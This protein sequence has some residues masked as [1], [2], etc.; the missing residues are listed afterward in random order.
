VPCLSLF[1]PAD[2][3]IFGASQRRFMPYLRLIR[4]FSSW[5]RK[6]RLFPCFLKNRLQNPKSANVHGGTIIPDKLFGF[7]TC[8]VLC[9]L[10]PMN[11]LTHLS[12][13][14][15]VLICRVHA[16]SI[17]LLTR[18]RALAITIATCTF[19]VLSNM[20]V[21]NRTASST[22]AKHWQPFLTKSV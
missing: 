22:V 15:L 21:I 11:R 19:S 20:F 7:L 6:L 3:S 2:R 12:F 16:K 10:F 5:A 17:C 8:L 9:R 13:S 4:N 14:N 1:A 18:S